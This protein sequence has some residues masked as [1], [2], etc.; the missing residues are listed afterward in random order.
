MRSS[1]ALGPPA[2]GPP[3]SAPG[4]CSPSV[5]STSSSPSSAL[6]PVH[7]LVGPLPATRQ[8]SDKDPVPSWPEG[9]RSLGAVS[10]PGHCP[11]LPCTGS[12]SSLDVQYPPLCPRAFAL[13]GLLARTFRS[14]PEPADRLIPQ[15]PRRGSPPEKAPRLHLPAITSLTNPSQPLSSAWV[16]VSSSAS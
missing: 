11:F 9:P 6:T 8:L 5:S 2:P 12:V 3:S 10:Q 16:L 13:A 7:P 15:A 1:G 14:S 4:V